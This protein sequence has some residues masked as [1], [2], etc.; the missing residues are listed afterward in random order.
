[1][2]GPKNAYHNPDDFTRLLY[3]CCQIWKNN[4]H[5]GEKGMRLFF[6]TNYLSFIF[7]VYSSFHNDIRDVVNMNYINFYLISIT[8]YIS[9][10][11]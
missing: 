6:D 7:V 11:F 1:M 9:V 4:V 5:P 10:T 8:G 2:P 3:F